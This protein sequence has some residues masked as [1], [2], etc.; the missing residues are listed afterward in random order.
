MATRMYFHSTASAEPGTLPTT[1]QSAKTATQSFESQ[2]TNRTLDTDI[3]S[4]QAVI[5]FL[6]TTTTGA[7]RTYYVS[8]FISPE[9]N[10]A[11]IAA[12]TWLYNFACK[13]GVT[14]SVDNYPINDTSLTCPLCCYVWRPSTGTKVGDIL[15]GS[16][17][18]GL[19]DVGNFGNNTTTEVSEDGSFTGAAVAGAQAGDVIVFE[20]WI[21][22]WTGT[23][24]SSTLAWFYDGGTVTRADGTIVSDHA[25]F[26]E[27]PENLLFVGAVASTASSS[28][29]FSNTGFLPAVG[30][31]FNTF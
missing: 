28:R 10:Q 27:T 12:N 24:T 22:V 19:Y 21:S 26:I 20:V 2:A 9:L 15:D 30:S 14:T 3:G 4:A 8:K 11:G 29:S 16:T 17:G 7:N 18:T 1:K 31:S 5:T 25:S 23:S 6:N 13:V